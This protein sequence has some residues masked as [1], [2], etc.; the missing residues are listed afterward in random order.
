MNAHDDFE[1]EPVR[2]LPAN[3]PAGERLIWQGSPQFGSLAIR[4]F[5]V[6]K[7]AL[8]FGALIV[9]RTTEM[10]LAG[11]PT[12]AILPGCLW[13]GFL[14][15]VLV[16]LL[17]LLA[18]LSAKNAVYSITTRRV[19][20]RHGVALQMSLNIPFKAVEGAGLLQH[21]DGTGD[22]ALTV[23]P[24]QRVAYIL[25]W[26][27]VRRWS[28]A[29]PEPMLRAVAN[30]AEVAALLTDAWRSAMP[31]S[32]VARQARAPVADTGGSARTSPAHGNVAGAAA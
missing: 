27:F 19:V 21:R 11:Q 10:G 31:P 26:P 29:R 15:V 28:L 12:A 24:K 9:W 22:V 18:W 25:T 13:L 20:I 3:L 32:E 7:A 17:S 2:G 1:F 6:R 16:G 4:A 30:P 5:H 8:Y 14:G 23:D